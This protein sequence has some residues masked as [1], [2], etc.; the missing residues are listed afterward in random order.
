MI[1][2]LS[3][4]FG[5]EVYTT[6]GARVGRVVDVNIDVNTRSVSDIFISNLD[7]AFQKK[8]GIEDKK[9]IIYSYSGIRNIQDIVLVSDMKP[10]ISESVDESAAP[11]EPA[12]EAY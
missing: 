10:L 12:S 3:K 1:T 4:V 2:K 7:S 8:Q 6:S 11:E 9:G 5:K